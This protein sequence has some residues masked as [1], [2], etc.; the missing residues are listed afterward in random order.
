MISISDK[1][2]IKSMDIAELSEF[3]S[4][5]SEPDYRAKQIFKWVQSGIQ[6]F[7]GMTDIPKSL[8]EKLKD[9]AYIACANIEKRYKSKLDSTVKYL[10]SLCD[11]E[12]VE[13]V[14]ME[15]K[16]GFT[17]CISSQVGCNM[18]CK[19]CAS[20]LFGKTRDLTPSEMLSQI[21][22]IQKDNDIRISNIVMMGMGEPLDNFENSI[23]F[24]HLV[25]HSDGLNIGLRHI[26]LSS[27]GVVSGIRKLGDCEMPITLSISL[28]APFD[29]IRNSIM[30]VNRKWNIEELLSACHEYQSKTHRRISFEYALIS[31]VNDSDRCAKELARIT[32]GIMCHI[33]L[34]PVNPVKENGYQKPNTEKINAFKNLLNTLGCNATVRRTLGADIS[35]SCGQLRK[36]A[37]EVTDIASVQ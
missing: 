30:P 29:D 24:L 33:N 34:I 5:L 1:I 11:G 4:G 17:A 35:A 19:F 14:L 22:A 26:S 20:G 15:Y 32:K 8:R 37:R 12:Y 13:S 9:R 3:L 31:G 18:G 28:H 21:T 27:C 10:F 36:K 6:S 23:K 7:D 2:D 25:S 16:H